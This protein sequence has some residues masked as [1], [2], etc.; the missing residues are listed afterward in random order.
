MELIYPGGAIGTILEFPIAGWNWTGLT[1]AGVKVRVRRP[2]RTVLERTGDELV[3]VADRCVVGWKVKAE[4]FNQGGRHRV[5]VYDIRAGGR[6]PTL[7]SVFNI[8]PDF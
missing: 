6:A 8:Q 3:V 2:D 4:D 7:T 5:R 1:S